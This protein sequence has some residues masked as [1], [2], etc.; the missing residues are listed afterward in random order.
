M[1]ATLTRERNLGKPVLN[2]TGSASWGACVSVLAHTCVLLQYFA[3]A[4]FSLFCM[5]FYIFSF[6][7]PLLYLVEREAMESN[8]RQWEATGG[9]SGSVLAFACVYLHVLAAACVCFCLAARFA[10]T[11][12]PTSGAR[13]GVLLRPGG[14]QIV[15]WMQ[16]LCCSALG[17]SN[18][19]LDS[20]SVLLRPW[21]AK[22]QF[23]SHF[24]AAPPIGAPNDHLETISVLL[25]PG[26]AK[27]E[28][29]AISVLLR[30]EGAKW[31]FGSH[32]CDAPRACQGLARGWQGLP[33]ACQGLPGACQRLARELQG[34][35]EACQGCHRV[36]IVNM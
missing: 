28:V 6:C 18:G 17:A 8:G 19:H 32:F 4:C 7:S 30:P 9:I 29:G 26:G 3:V 14:R 10:R 1:G 23:G 12:A 27:W 25:R 11:T 22:L 34:L 31:P 21:G 24:C 15:I 16:F 13:S 36:C 35:P 5:C 2:R 33:G 20:I